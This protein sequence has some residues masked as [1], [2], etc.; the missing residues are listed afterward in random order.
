MGKAS[1]C[2]MV[3]TISPLSPGPSGSP[4]SGSTISSSAMS[5]QIWM[6]FCSAHSRKSGPDSSLAP[7]QL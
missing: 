1:F 2:S 7:K 3:I 6:P 4:V 5:P